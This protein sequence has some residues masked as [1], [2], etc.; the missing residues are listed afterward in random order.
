MFIRK[1]GWGILCIVWG[2][3]FDIADTYS[4]QLLCHVLQEQALED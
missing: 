1:T 4:G 3:H 2:V